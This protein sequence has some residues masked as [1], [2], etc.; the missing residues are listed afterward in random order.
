[1]SPWRLSRRLLIETAGDVA[2]SAAAVVLASHPGAAAASGALAPLVSETLGMAFDRQRFRAANVLEAAAAASGLPVGELVQRLV[3]SAEAEE[4][5]TRTLRAAADATMSE[6]LVALAMS[7]AEVAQAEND[8][9]VAVEAAFIRALEDCDASHIRVLRAFTSTSNEL[10]LGDGS[11]AF[12]EPLDGLNQSQLIMVIPDLEDLLPP[13]LAVLQRQGL[14]Y[15]P[16]STASTL[17]GGVVQ[18]EHTP[19]QLTPFGKDFLTRIEEVA[20]WIGKAAADD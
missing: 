1:V 19:W 5:L 14:V 13:I 18:L 4:L 8:G 10:G 9:E 11:E 12:D 6:K 17:G 15:S 7:L 2:T 3:E 16:Q 20:A